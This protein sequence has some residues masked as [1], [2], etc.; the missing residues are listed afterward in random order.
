MLPQLQHDPASPRQPYVKLGVLNQTQFPNHCGGWC[1]CNGSSPVG[2]THLIAHND[3]AG[4]LLS[5]RC[6]PGCGLKT[7]GSSG[8]RHGLLGMQCGRL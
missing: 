2:P 6:A 1:G 7:V 3:A 4:N 8:A 5:G